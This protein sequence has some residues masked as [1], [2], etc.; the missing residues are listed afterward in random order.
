[1]FLKYICPIKY[2]K[3]SKSHNIFLKKNTR[4]YSCLQPAKFCTV[5]GSRFAI[6]ARLSF[7]AERG[8]PLSLANT[9]PGSGSPSASLLILHHP[10]FTIPALF[11]RPVASSPAAHRR[12]NHFSLFSPSP[13]SYVPFTRSFSLTAAASRRQSTA[14]AFSS[15]FRCHSSSSS[16]SSSL[17]AAASAALTLDENNRGWP[18]G[19]SGALLSSTVAPDAAQKEKIDV[20]PPKGT[21][22]FPPEEM[23]IRNWLFRNFREVKLLYG[24]FGL[25]YYA[26]IENNK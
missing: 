25:I 8:S 22:D 24:I 23:R 7:G 2:F 16:P 17:S 1:M 14:A 26:R 13:K 18:S 10:R 21:R 3:S 6:A 4:V 11:L 12:H 5:D 15:S 20:N 19:R 9:M